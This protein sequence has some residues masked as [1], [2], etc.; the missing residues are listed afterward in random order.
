M[1][2][3][4]LDFG[5][6]SV[7]YA[8]IREDGT[9]IEAG[10]KAAPLASKMQFLQ[11]A[12]E[13]Y[14]QYKHEIQGVS[15]SIPGYVDAS[16]GL[17]IGSGAYR[18]LYGC[19]II[20][21]LHETIPVNIAVE[22]DGKCGALAEGWR[23]ALADGGSGVVLI[24]GSG[25]AGGI[26]QNGRIYAGDRLAAAEFSNY[27]VK[28]DDPTFRGL[29]VMNCAAFGLTYKLCKAK[30]LDFS[31]QDYAEELKNT[32][33]AFGHI[34]P[35]MSLPPK[36][37]KA[38]GKQL[39]EWI[40]EGDMQA[41]RVY[42]EF[43]SSLAFL[44]FNIQITLAPQKIVVGGGLSRLP[45]MIERTQTRLREIY[46]TTGVGRE[47]QAEVVRSKYLDECNLMGAAYNYILRF[48]Q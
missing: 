5:G 42:D 4:I 27:L 3:L 12:T 41:K 43:I 24:L 21:L 33:A 1:K 8:T 44:I 14:E 11:T 31:Y 2:L 29:A 35:P 19:N 48:P 10:K 7:K 6:T 17:L 9:F 37:I 13:I 28:P 22:N 20:E 25:I 26:L 40:N 18:K 23:G 34:Y 36:R 15:I 38:D 32:D 45:G 47:L 16:S 30:N 46:R 39:S